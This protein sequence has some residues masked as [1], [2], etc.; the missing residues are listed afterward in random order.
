MQPVHV[1]LYLFKMLFLSF[2]LLC[3]MTYKVTYLSTNHSSLIMKNN[4]RMAESNR[5]K[6]ILHKPTVHS[7]LYQ[8]TNSL[9]L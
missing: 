4:T 3:L 2:Q 1:Y 9:T 8:I 5:K 6:D 7:Q